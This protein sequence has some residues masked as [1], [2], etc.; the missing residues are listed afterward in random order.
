M[1]I[2]TH[3]LTGTIL[4]ATTKEI[5]RRRIFFWIGCAIAPDLDML[6]GLGGSFAYYSYHRGILHGLPGALLLILLLAWLFP[7]I[8]SGTF[9]QGFIFS[10]TAIL[11]HLFLDL[12]TSFGIS[13]FYPFSSKDY[14]MD[15]VFGFDLWLGGGL[16]ICSALGCIYPRLR[17]KSAVSGLVLIIG[18][19]CFCFL[20]Q[21]RAKNMLKDKINTGRI[22]EGTITALPQPFS[23]MTWAGFISTPQ[24]IYAGKL[25][26]LH[27]GSIDLKFYAEPQ[28]KKFLEIANQTKTAHRFLAFARF[29]YIKETIEKDKITFYYSD[30]RFSISGIERSNQYIGIKIEVGFNGD[31]IYEGKIT[32]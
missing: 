12:G 22:P 26:L 7:R 9:I 27:P 32:K 10:G 23:P 17:K 21:N 6:S 8:T 3:G 5:S 2:I 15:L 4:G 19:L 11:S 14:Y 18:Y 13:L 28:K 30:L 29:P 24:G 1:D 31:I 20:C 16:L 25:F